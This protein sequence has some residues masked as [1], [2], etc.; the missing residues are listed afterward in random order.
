MSTIMSRSGAK[1]WWGVDLPKGVL[2][3]SREQPGD[4][5]IEYTKKQQTVKK[6]QNQNCNISYKRRSEIK[7]PCFVWVFY[8]KG[9]FFG[10][11][12]IYIK[13]AYE[14]YRLNFRT[15]KSDV[16]IK[17]MALF[18]C[19]ILP[20]IA[21]VTDWFKAFAKEYNH[22]GFNRGLQGWKQG[23][24]QCWCLIN[25]NKEIEDIYSDGR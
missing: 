19:G 18:P 24:A 14:D 2:S 7:K 1:Y 23:L 17:C 16:I 9:F 8:N 10:G 15:V 12:Y 13:T 25:E 3:L 20:E 11:W 21:F 5:W 4:K 6:I 22:I